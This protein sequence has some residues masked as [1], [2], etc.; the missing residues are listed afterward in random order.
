MRTEALLPIRLTS[1]GPHAVTLTVDRVG[2]DL[3]CGVHG[4]DAHVGS[5]ALSEWRGGRAN[6]RCLSAEGHRE[7]AIARHAAHTLCA[8][9]RRT[10]SCV[11]GIH[12]ENI[13]RADIESISAAAYA[14]ARRAGEL[15]RDE[16]IARE[17]A[18]G[19][20]THERI[21]AR[22]AVFEARLS[23]LFSVPVP[24]LL[25]RYRDDIEASRSEAFGDAVR[26]FA[27]LY[28]SNACTNDC[29]YCGFR[30]SSDYE[31]TRLSIREAVCEAAALGERGIRAIDLV[32]GEIPA[33]PF[34]DYVCEV[35]AAVLGDTDITRVHLNVGS[36][37]T[38]Q[39]GRLRRAGAAGAHVYQETYD[40]QA[41]F[42]NHRSGGKREMASRLDAPRRAAVAGFEY[43]GLGVLLGL[44]DLRSD[45]AS[46]V[47][48]GELLREEFPGL[49]IG[50]SLPRVQ[51]ME[52]DPEYVP[53]QP[54]SDDDFLRSMLFLRLSDPHG[55]LTL[56]T[57]ERPEIRDLLLRFGVTKLSA[58][59][60]TAPGGYAA[61]GSPGSEAREQFHV[62][63]VRTV[64]DIVALV[65][66]AG[67]T[68]VF[69]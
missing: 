20:G 56:T 64:D 43:V 57:R 34:V 65:S 8:A 24:D 28:L 11:A 54:V 38:E 9:A 58:G 52:A 5:V 62:A 69:E 30:R 51:E 37:S 53:G 27:P 25:E 40:A 1:E 7:E 2:D 4:G 6:T 12:F 17:V 50:F 68:P 21:A 47:A 31:R 39:Y 14:L 41:Y 60:S 13:G 46:L 45:L 23:D 22:R 44:A 18:V 35:T 3:L 36:L 55:H 26:L 48:H 66:Q 32:T 33:D 42:A 59:V 29:V 10:V 49:D 16:R 67:L 19:G 15:L 63:D 61:R